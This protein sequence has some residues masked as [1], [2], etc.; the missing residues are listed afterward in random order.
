MNQD[1][2]TASI[3]IDADPAAVWQVVSDL[4][5]MGEWSPQCRK[6]FVFGG[7]VKNG[8]RTLNLNHS[9]AM[10]WPTTAKVVAFE[11][12]R[13]IAFRI[14]ENRTIWTYE[15]EPTGGGTKLTESRTIPNGITGIS[16]FLTARLFGGTAT[17]EDMLARG[18]HK[19]LAQIKDEVER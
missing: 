7:P 1:N 13:K 14:T 8:T 6:M 4:K 12:E 3:D 11:P 18:I 15:L 9:G 19:T 2:I 10:H 17:F 16:N 5:R